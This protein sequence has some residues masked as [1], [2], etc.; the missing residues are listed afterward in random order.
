M[1]QRDDDYKDIQN[2]FQS[3]FGE[4]IQPETERRLRNRFVAFRERFEQCTSKTTPYQTV[5]YGR[6][7]WGVGVVTIAILI[8]TVMPGL[9]QSPGDRVYAAAAKALQSVDT[10]H[11]SGWS[12]TLSSFIGIHSSDIPDVS[13]PLE[14]EA[15]EWIDDGGLFH[16]YKQGGPYFVREDAERR[17]EYN[18]DTDTLWIKKPRIELLNKA[19]TASIHLLD[20]L[21][22]FDI[23]KTNLADREIGG[24]LCNGLLTEKDV[25]R[26][27]YWFDK[28]TNLLMELS[29]YRLQNGD[30]KQTTFIQFDYDQ[31]I[32]QAVQA[33]VGPEKPRQIH[34]DRDIDP[35]FDAWHERLR[36]LASRYTTQP[37]PKTMELVPRLNEEIIVAYEYGQMPGI[38]DYLVR[39]LQSSLGDYLRRAQYN[40]TI[41]VPKKLQ[42]ISLNHDLVLQRDIPIQDQT[43]F[44]LHSLG[45]E[46]VENKEERNVWIAH[47]DGRALKPWKEVK[48]P[49]SGEGARALMPG[50]AHGWNPVALTDLINAFNYWQDDDLSAS[51]TYIVDETELPK[52]PDPNANREPYAVCCENIYWGGEESKEIAQEWF[53]KE[54]G[55]TFSEEI[56]TLATWIVREKE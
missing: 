47:H 48:A 6:L 8:L 37:F 52:L 24:R 38:R 56:R 9:F 4:E 42:D 26:K 18:A 22:K 33:Y 29:F 19:S 20:A 36:Q 2:L 14:I 28:K 5:W 35:R 51:G 30:W 46:I 16:S 39:P 34:Y 32:P 41:R 53:A 23:Q 45:L 31:A 40:G 50:M 15:W 44:I 10:I 54:L 43:I 13:K 21:Q 25:R 17:Y 7:A 3:A 27:E 12:N 55:I 49:V 1:T 11:I